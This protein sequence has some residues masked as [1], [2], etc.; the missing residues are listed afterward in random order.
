M[1]GPSFAVR[2][3]DLDRV[4]GVLRGEL[5]P[6]R[7]RPAATVA[8]VRDGTGG[9]EVYLMRRVRQMAFGAGMHV[10]PG[11]SVEPSD[12]QG[13]EGGDWPDR[14]ARWWA[15]RLTAGS[16]LAAALVRAAIRETAEECGVVLTPDLLAPLAHWI[17]PEPEPRRYD[18]R[19]FLAALPPGQEAREAG[20]EADARLWIRPADVF[21]RGLAVMPPTAAVL[22]QLDGYPDVASALS[23]EREIR[24]VQPRMRL[25]G[26]RLLLEIP[27]C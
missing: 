20:T 6:V 23:A 8:L 2:P 18:T 5:P 3:E 15:G 9:P 22:R 16:E 27:P 12:H 4:R 21:A 24:V 19:F 11:G 14:P 10:F 17:T 25:S 13:E 1:T 7:P 26:D